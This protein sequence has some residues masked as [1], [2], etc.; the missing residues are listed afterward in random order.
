MRMLALCLTYLLVNA[1]VI[2][3]N[4]RQLRKG[5]FSGKWN[6]EAGVDLSVFDRLLPISEYGYDNSSTERTSI[7]GKQEVMNVN[8]GYIQ[9]Y[10]TPSK[11]NSQQ[12]KGK[13]LLVTGNKNKEYHIRG[14][15]SNS[16]DKMAVIMIPTSLQHVV[17]NKYIAESRIAHSFID[18]SY[19][20]ELFGRNE[21]MWL[22]T[23]NTTNELLTL[24]YTM[25]NETSVRQSPPKRR[26]GERLWAQTKAAIDGDGCVWFAD[27]DVR[28]ETR[29]I[30][31]HKSKSETFYFLSGSLISLTC[32]TTLSVISS[33]EYVVEETD[34]SFNYLLAGLCVTVIHAWGVSRQISYARTRSTLSRISWITFLNIGTFEWSLASYHWTIL[35]IMPALMRLVMAISFFHLMVFHFCAR[36]AYDS[37]ESQRYQSRIW[38]LPTLSFPINLLWWLTENRLY[39]GDFPLWIPSLFIVHAVWVPQIFHSA[40]HSAVRPVT[41]PLLAT[42]LLSRCYYSSFRVAGQSVFTPFKSEPAVYFSLVLWM[43]VQTAVVVAQQVFGPTFFIPQKMLSPAYDYHGPLPSQYRIAPFEE[44]ER[45]TAR[46]RG[47]SSNAVA[48]LEAGLGPLSSPSVPAEPLDC[49]ICQVCT[50]LTMDLLQGDVNNPSC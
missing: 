26:K 22:Q 39:V 18:S 15:V 6:A 28:N 42:T 9:L 31:Y 41:M 43:V 25:P 37:L 48:D 11:N 33:Q 50:F 32:N 38:L 30:P 5:V 27:F 24:N 7:A 44:R 10:L 47:M 8:P 40:K 2:Q 45:G 34:D 4:E 17:V 16:S 21:T 49:V 14:V 12:L 19:A 20:V 35:D 29:K 1:E 36:H 23:R 46:K 13:V 3:S